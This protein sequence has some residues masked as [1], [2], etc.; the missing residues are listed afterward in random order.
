MDSY[1]LP[2][3][4]VS[5][6]G[7]ASPIQSIIT[8]LFQLCPRQ[9]EPGAIQ[10]T[11][12]LVSE[13]H[14]GEVIPGWVA[15]ATASVQTTLDPLL[16]AGPAG[17][18]A[19]IARTGNSIGCAWLNE[20][21][22]E[23][24]FVASAAN[25]PQTNRPS[26]TD[27]PLVVKSTPH[28]GSVELSVQSVLIPLLR[29]V[30]LRRNLILIH[31]AA[32]V[33]PDGTGVLFVADGGGGK[34]TTVISVLRKGAHLLGDD[35]VAIQADAGRVRAFGL[36]EP[37]NLTENTIRFFD[38]LQAAANSI[39][40]RP[41]F[42]KKTVTPQQIYGPDCLADQCDIHAVYFVH[43][44]PEGPSVRP[45]PAPDTLNRLFQAHRFAREQRIAAGSFEQLSALV[46]RARCY[47]LSTGPVPAALGAWLIANCAAHAGR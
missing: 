11:S 12:R 14:L 15:Q 5:V 31:S 1:Q 10:I 25:A 36:P 16:I 44:T 20:A 42:H 41:D 19:V 30:L 8:A 35:L 2:G 28:G 17:E 21:G 9:K 46:T 24:T 6:E 45:L 3:V 26:H 43:V 32:A 29:E 27:R 34:T 38:E 47:E 13:S 33:C 39:P 18:P 37:M 23:I 40:G 22:T 4:T 7:P